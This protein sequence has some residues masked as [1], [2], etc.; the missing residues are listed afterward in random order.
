[1]RFPHYIDIACLELSRDFVS[2][3]PVSERDEKLE[4][5]LMIAWAMSDSQW[6]S[7]S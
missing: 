6:R 7:L 3:V 2:G 1:M 5:I 4:D